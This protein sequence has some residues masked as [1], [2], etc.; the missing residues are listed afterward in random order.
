M[1]AKGVFDGYDAVMMAHPAFANA[2]SI[3]TIAMDAYKIEFFGK[4]HM[5]RQPRMKEST[6][7]MR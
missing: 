7:L 6:H 5:Q 3:N 2:E 1:S 4:P